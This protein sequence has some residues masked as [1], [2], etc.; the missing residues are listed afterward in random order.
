MPSTSRDGGIIVVPL[1]YHLGV[2]GLAHLD[3]APANRGRSI[4]ALMVMPH[5]GGLFRRA[6]GQS[7]PGTFRRHDRFIRGHL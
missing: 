5:C 4:A 3:G 1:N 6:I 2:E 7:L